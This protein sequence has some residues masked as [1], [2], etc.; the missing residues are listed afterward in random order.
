MALFAL[1]STITGSALAPRSLSYLHNYYNLGGTLYPREGYEMKY[2]YSENN[3]DPTPSALYVPRGLHVSADGSRLYCVLGDSLYRVDGSIPASRI[4]NIGASSSATGIYNAA[5]GYNYIVFADA[6]GV[7]AL[8]T[9]ADTFSG[10]STGSYS[11]S[12][13]CKD[14]EYVDGRFVYISGSDSLVYWSEVND[15]MNVDALSFFD[16]ESRPDTNEALAV[17]GNDL[18][19]FGD[20]SVERFRSTGNAAAPFQRVTNSIIA[21]GYVGGMIK[22]SDRVVFIGREVG[23]GVG[24]YELSGSS[25][26]KIST[27]PVDEMLNVPLA[28]GISESRLEIIHGQ[29]WDSYGRAVYCFSVRDLGGFTATSGNANTDLD[30]SILS[31]YAIRE[32][33]AYQW[34]FL[35]DNSDNAWANTREWGIQDLDIS[36]AAGA[37]VD[38]SR[39]FNFVSH[40]RFNGEWLCQR[41]LGY[42]S[43]GIYKKTEGDSTSNQAIDY[44]DENEPITK[45]FRGYVRS[46]EDNDFSLSSIEVSFSKQG[47]YRQSSNSNPS[48]GDSND[49]MTL[50][51]SQTGVGWGYGIDGE[52]EGKDWSTA[53]SIP[54]G[55]LGDQGRAKF[56]KSGGLTA[57]N[58]YLGLVV[59]SDADIPLFIE[60][61]VTEGM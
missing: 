61:A 29:S 25:L 26:R 53:I 43:A 50:R 11:L 55:S 23:S 57:S 46:T 10:T 24:V 15:P 17:I 3:S 51:T 35:S 34:G 21:V 60:K 59:E 54:V 39:G 4:T 52:T 42:D 41:G 5:V 30:I 38:F 40:V 36:T 13:V 44:S 2:A 19:V 22:L 27:P 16:A 56:I 33:G 20:R 14:V 7:G 6:A 47:S 37:G 9:S 48:G 45:G 18:Y 28:A 49:T 31:L 1:P 8:D 32:N 58:G 12:V